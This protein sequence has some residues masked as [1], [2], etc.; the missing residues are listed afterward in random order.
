MA[1][2]LTRVKITWLILAIII[3]FC[4][5]SS[6]S[7]SSSPS[8]KCPNDLSSKCKCENHPVGYFIECNAAG[9]NNVN[10]IVESLGKIRVQRL[11]I[12]GAS[13]PVSPE[14]TYLTKTLAKLSHAT[15]RSL[16]LITCGIKQI[17]QNAFT[18]L[19][20]V[21][22]ELVLSNNSL[23]AIP[24][25]GSLPRLLSLNLNNNLLTDISEGALEGAGNLR[26]L[27]VES[28]KIC[29]L[30]RNSLNESKGSLELLDMSDNCLTKIPAQNLRN[31]V[32]LMYVDLSENKITDIANF[33]VM[34]LPML[35]ELRINGNKLK[36]ISP[37]AFMNVPQL[38]YLY[39]KNNL[40]ES[41]ESSRLFQ[42][43]KQ[44]EV[45][46]LSENR[47]T[48]IPSSKELSNIRQIRL[49][50]N[51]I[52]DIGTLSFSSNSRLQLISVQN[53]RI[54][55]IARNSFDA[56]EQLSILLLAN[57]TIKTLERGMLD[58]MKNLQQLNL[59]NNSLNE[60]PGGVFGSL[61]QLTT[62]DLAHNAL[63]KIHKNAF[64]PLKKLFWLDLSSNKL[65]TF[66]KGTFQQRI[67]NVLL[68]GN[69]LNCD[70]KLDWFV[71]Y[72][73]LNQIR[74][75]LPYQREITCAAPKKY[76]GIRL[77]ELMMK[78]ANE[79]IQSLNAQLKAD[80]VGGNLISDLLQNNMEAALPAAFRLQQPQN[81]LANVPIVGAITESIPSLRN[82][83]G[84]R[85]IPKVEGERAQDVQK[86][87]S[88]IEQLS[89]PIVRLSTGG[90]PLISDIEDIVKAA[91]NLIVSVPGLGNI[92]VTKL[93]PPVIAHVLRGGQIPGIPKQTM[94]KIVR[95]FMQHMHAAADA[96]N[97]GHPLPDGQLYLP[98]LQKLPVELVTNFINGQ[99]LPYLNEQQTAAISEYYTA[100]LP[101]ALGNDNGKDVMD[102][103][104]KN[105]KDSKKADDENNNNGSG[106]SDGSIHT[107][108]LPLITA[109]SMSAGFG[110]PPQ[111]IE[112]LKLLPQ[113]YDIGKI[114]REVM[115]AVSRGEIPDFNLLPRDLQE[116]FI[117]NSYRLFSSFSNTPN[118]TIE[119]ILKSLP[120]FERPQRPTFSPYD[121]NE[122]NSEL[123]KTEQDQEKE[124]RIHYISA[125]LL[126]LVGAISIAVLVLL[127]CYMRRKRITTSEANLDEDSL[128]NPWQIPP[129]RATSSP[130]DPTILPT[131]L[132]NNLNLTPHRRHA[133]SHLSSQHEQD[134][135]A[136]PEFVKSV[137]VCE[138]L[139]NGLALNCSN[140]NA[141][142][143]VQLLR[144]N[145]QSLGLIQQLILQ[146][147]QL[148][149]QLPANFFTGLF[150]KKLDLSHNQITSIHTQAFAANNILQEIS[151]AY[152]R[153]SELPS[154]AF[155]PLKSLLKLDLSNNSITDL[156]PE[157]ALPSLP[158]LYDLN[159]AD[160]RICRIHKSI[161]D[162]VRNNIQT[163][164]LGRNCLDSIPAPAIRGFKQL[165]ALHLHGNNITSLNALSFM[166]LPQMNLLNLAT[167]QIKEIHRQAFLNVP[168]L[169]YLYLTENRIT[170]I[171]AHQ[172][173][174]FEQ[175]EML[176]FTS[177]TLLQL[178]TDAFSNLKNLRQLYLGENR[179]AA[180]E[181]GAFTNSSVVILVLNSNRL[182]QLNERM[183]DGL[184]K[185]Q[186]ISLKDNQID[187][188]DH[189]TFYTNPS[190]V[191]ID[192]SDNHLLDIASGTFLTQTN[193]FLV[194]LSG[195]KL[196]RTPY[197][198][199]SRRVKTVLLQENPLVCTERVHMLQE[200]VGVYIPNS[201]DAIC[202]SIDHYS[203]PQPQQQ[204]SIDNPNNLN[205]S[206]SGNSD[207][208]NDATITQMAQQEFSK[209]TEG[210]S[211][212]SLL[213]SQP[214][215]PKSTPFIQDII[216]NETNLKHL[217]S[218]SQSSV[219]TIIQPL[220]RFS[221]Q[222]NNDK[223]SESNPI[224]MSDDSNTNSAAMMSNKE[225]HQNQ[226]QNNLS[227]IEINPVTN[228]RSRS[229]FG[230][231]KA[232]HLDRI[233]QSNDNFADSTD[234]QPTAIM[235][236]STST[237]SPSS[238]INNN[239][240]FA[241]DNPNVIHP[242]PV[243]FLKQPPKIFPAYAANTL[244]P[245]IVVLSKDEN[246][247]KHDEVINSR[248][249]RQ[250]ARKY[251][252]VE[253]LQSST[254][255]TQQLYDTNNSAQQQLHPSFETDS[256]TSNKNIYCRLQQLTTPSV[257]ITICLSTVGIVM[258]AVFIGLC[259]AKH[260][261]LREQRR[262]RLRLCANSNSSTASNSCSNSAAMRTNAYVAAQAAHINN[263]L[264]G[265]VDRYKMITRSLNNQILSI[266]SIALVIFTQ[267]SQA[268][269]P[270]FLKNQTACSCFAYIDG[271]VI[272]CNGP[273]GPAV[274][275]Q[276]KRTPLEIREL[277]LE[278]ANIVEIGRN[279]FK[280]LRI[281]KLVLDNNRI[282]ALHPDAFRGLESV[283]QHLSISMN[284]LTAVPTD[285]LIAMR[286]L[287]VLSLRCN[288]ITNISTPIFR[289][290]SSLIDLNLACNQICNIE[291]SAF[292]DV[293]GTL[294][295]LILDNNCLSSIPSDAIRNLDN[296]IGL[297]LK[298][299]KIQQLEKLQLM[300]L[301]SLTI[302]TLTGNN[303]STIQKNV[304]PDAQSLK[305]LYLSNNNLKT[306][307]PSVF[308]QFPEIQV[309]D[310]SYNYLTEITEDMFTDLEHLQH[311]NLEGNQITEVSPGSFAT[312]PLLLLWLPNNCLSS[313]SANMF[314][315]APFLR[316]VS[317]AN[318]N[319][320]NIQPLSFA[321]LAN[322]HTLD[323]SHNKIQVLQPGAI[324]GSDHLTVRLQENPMVCSQDGFHVMNG[325]EAINL[326]T[327]PN[328][329]CKSDYLTE[330]KDLCPKKSVQRPQPPTC[331]NKPM[332]TTTTAATTMI[333]STTAVSTDE[334]E[335][336]ITTTF[337]SE[338]DF[339][340]ES[341]QTTD[342]EESSV[343]AS[344]ATLSR[345]RKLNLERFFRLSQRPVDSKF[346]PFLRH[347][348]PITAASEKGDHAESS[349]TQTRIL[350]IS[351][352]GRRPS[353]TSTKQQ[354]LLPKMDRPVPSRVEQRQRQLALTRLAASKSQQK[355]AY[356]NT[357]D[358]STKHKQTKAETIQF[359]VDSNV[360][361]VQLPDGE[362]PLR[363][364]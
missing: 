40:L 82:L 331:C 17:E 167:N 168:N 193:I 296:L 55:S 26:H 144:T 91:P 74:T 262:N 220:S 174:S 197:A 34:N 156:K 131:F 184:S 162:H 310:L 183:F 311:L 254:K 100:R 249:N 112:M 343:E 223:W 176:D 72:L 219:S 222:A 318:N 302:L 266:L 200:G 116:H 342:Q 251:E 124:T 212:S 319:I 328:L 69:P 358:D 83:P 263:M 338:S 172:F 153:L 53:N 185:L 169:R 277:A 243:P 20:E 177:N 92:D 25:L 101:I 121:L 115:E 226:N 329:I 58:G 284:R 354:Q 244:P 120:K 118:V 138:E 247:D 136:C 163:M 257:I 51:R 344:S 271:I 232:N 237:K 106:A 306:L 182:R 15:I 336:T 22:E 348:M 171:F 291:G 282:R 349:S 314:Q 191:M 18:E 68:D 103:N 59:R 323:L 181:T 67:A 45:L 238:V 85:F 86:L 203:T 126:G 117:Q 218:P 2:T 87:N 230:F 275:E 155:I 332:P 46:D 50:S 125:I 161:F 38:Q 24:L 137:C 1:S 56:L 81:P 119:D 290:L 321:H 166:N 276:L 265:T 94:D 211:S 285:S 297:H 98:P 190:L 64:V 43:L 313:V 75:F 129:P 259:I 158:K 35:K 4:A 179:I 108:K 260:Q 149:R 264:Y 32:R 261:R 267:Q 23:T 19:T 135:N 270:E 21:L 335:L 6:V 334:D 37:M 42:V 77:K 327:E 194:D 225:K 205:A 152:N 202:A 303:I 324:T 215:S 8:S 216:S 206:S 299:N 272:K 14:F 41:L 157:H 132:D 239:D 170:Q 99:K 333:S 80:T 248:L 145:Q 304:M 312:T 221:S 315:G 339:D 195:N 363:L 356:T 258:S 148:N 235:T 61:P 102:G 325:R 274:V 253:L 280:N 146:N 180:I 294:Q 357:N 54:T 352:T 71:E 229:K 227:R 298:Y 305:Y 10:A 196:I 198:A 199:F 233:F 130:K 341:T 139:N 150:I 268:L 159:L 361:S 13:W 123:T 140:S 29:S 70:E 66:E 60:L 217:P 360:E 269:C 279:A 104:D 234:Q 11:T 337:P 359:N 350:S 288:A 78:K 95:E 88:A 188:I 346:S 110:L 33:E 317:L 111:L 142:H 73:V 292:E 347:H 281:K 89:A 210:Q 289:N 84:L 3:L 187:T 295:N 231:A 65:S 286:A 309:I 362:A 36:S 283:M 326:T 47:L 316:Q 330:T 154:D 63:R 214:S 39:L 278:N 160:N 76:A 300:N 340:T 213:Q 320:H 96:A 255:T 178:P 52:T 308:S 364:I 109:N 224:M 240:R 44:L 287:N 245:N 122:V 7:V 90:M 48:K 49:D 189:K 127:C 147:A 141:L 128:V 228:S 250:N 164:N 62:I 242:F 30:S 207:I 355:A 57:N 28:N 186:Q 105:D 236:T 273:Q 173:S 208:E 209:A 27:R 9:L 192:L 114:P 113:G 31:C 79:T 345:N 134:I 97:Q 165:M 16:H 256:N 246:G 151:L 252:P 204:Q 93:P 293:K 241:V 5:T 201:A 301:P 322:L 351:P 175:L 143:T 133:T 12:T 307:E 353:V 107:S